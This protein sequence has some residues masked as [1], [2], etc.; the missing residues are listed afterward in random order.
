MTTSIFVNKKSIK[1]T[2]HRWQ[3]F[4]SETHNIR[5]KTADVTTDEIR[6]HIFFGLED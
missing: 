4:L 2:K 3:C 5:E 1:L 6:K